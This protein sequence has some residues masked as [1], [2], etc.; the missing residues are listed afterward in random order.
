MKSEP[1]ESAQDD[2]PKDLK[3]NDERRTPV[4]SDELDNS[5]IYCCVGYFFIVIIAS[6][7]VGSQVGPSLYERLPGPDQCNLD[8]THEYKPS[9]MAQGP[10]KK[11]EL[12]RSGFYL[13]FLD[14]GKI[15]DDWIRISIQPYAA[16]FTEQDEH[17]IIYGE[18]EMY[19]YRLDD[20]WNFTET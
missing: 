18:Y 6:L 19:L 4:K 17:D 8:R 3:L 20:D 12:N 15:K 7:I 1:E 5:S 9:E 11:L 13:G 10:C 16:Y 2:K 14:S